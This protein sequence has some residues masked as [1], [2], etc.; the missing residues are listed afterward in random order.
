M[1]DVDAWGERILKAAIK[2]PGSRAQAIELLGASVLS[3]VS[4]DGKVVMNDR[5]SAKAPST[6]EATTRMSYML[7]ALEAVRDARNEEDTFDPSHLDGI[8]A[9]GRAWVAE[10]SS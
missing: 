8:I 6:E 9:K 5:H 7:R 4:T 1:S 3:L 10:H 2:T